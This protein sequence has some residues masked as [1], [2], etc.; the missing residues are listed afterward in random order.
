M[1]ALRSPWP[2]LMPGERA[3]WA[4]RVAEMLRETG[5]SWRYLLTSQPETASLLLHHRPS[6]TT[7]WLSTQNQYRLTGV[8]MTDGGR[9]RFASLV[10]SSSQRGSL[11]LVRRASVEE[12]ASHVRSAAGSP[13]EILVRKAGCGAASLEWTLQQ[14]CVIVR[15]TTGEMIGTLSNDGFRMTPGGTLLHKLFW[16]SLKS[17]GLNLLVP[18]EFM[19]EL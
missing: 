12:K 11:N 13:L 7:I 6:C 8:T 3:T 14:D 9:V 10:G 15:A 1:E 17:T 5:R 2:T 19:H 4:L 18:V 16:L